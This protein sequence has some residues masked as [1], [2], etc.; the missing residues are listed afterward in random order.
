M[1]SC[2]GEA[3]AFESFLRTQD[4]TALKSVDGDGEKKQTDFADTPLRSLWARQRPVG[5]AEDT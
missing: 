3:L 1:S 5:G 2:R 4:L